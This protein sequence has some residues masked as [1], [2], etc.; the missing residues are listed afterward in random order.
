L[1]VGI[2]YS[3][4]SS[5]TALFVVSEVVG[6]E[7]PPHSHVFVKMLYRKKLE[8]FITSSLTFLAL[9]S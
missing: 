9:I 5:V 7:N 6:C 3:F 8:T 1:F 2:F 4:P